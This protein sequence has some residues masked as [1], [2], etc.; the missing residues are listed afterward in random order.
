MKVFVNGKTKKILNAMVF[1]APYQKKDVANYAIITDD[2]ISTIKIVFDIAITNVVIRPQRYGIKYKII[3][4]Y[5]V[6]LYPEKR[7][8]FSVEPDSKIENS[9]Q[10]F[11]GMAPEIRH[12]EYENVIS[13]ESG[14]HF[15]DTIL[16]DKDNTLIY[17]KEGSIVH[18]RIKFSN[19]K[20]VAV[21]GF[22]ELTY[23]AYTNRTQLIDVNGCSDVKI[24][25]ITMKSSSNWNTR[26]LGCDRVH[27]DNIKIIGYRGNSDGVDVCSS[28]DVL[29][30]NIFTRVWDDSLVVK[31]L[32]CGDVYNVTFK[33]CV[34]WNDFA[35]PME[36]GVENRADKIY[37]IR[38][39]DIDLIHSVTGYPIMGI[40]HGDRAEIYDIYFENI[41]IEH[42]PGAQLLDLRVIPSAWNKDNIIGRIHNIYFKNINVISDPNAEILPYHSRIQG[43]SNEN[44]ISDIYFENISIF[45]KTARNAQE[46]GLQIF[47]YVDNIN[48]SATK[49]PFIERVKTKIKVMDY[50][51]CDDGNYDVSVKVILENTTDIEKSGSVMLKLSPEWKSKYDKGIEYSI[52]AHS[53]AEFVKRIKLPAGKYAFSLDSSNS[54]LECAVEFLNLKLLLTDKFEDCPSYYFCDSY[55]NS[56][57]EEVKFALKNDLLMIKTELLKKYNITL[58]AAKTFENAMVGDVLF[59]TEDTNSGKAPAIL[60]G[61]N[62]E[63]LE[64]PQIGCPEEIAFVFKNYPKVDIKNITLMRQ[65]NDIAIIPLSELDIKDGKNGFLLELVLQAKPEKRYEFTLFASPINKLTIRDPKVMAHMFIDAMGR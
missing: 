52:G 9:V 15:A 54:D 3:D 20:N 2:D 37:N 24:R 44:N 64:G 38:F 7:Y 5:T 18:G 11:C 28:R 13:F 26:I 61:K 12:E 49:G 48:F 30:E 57:D 29:V 65:L 58:Y 43:Y 23:E 50:L 34:L 39:L 6:E 4:E 19:C 47:D 63:Y 32:D 16:V 10:I 53:V 60:L 51:L 55:G 42:T 8:N 35:R 62:G 27:I 40:H 33:N 31:G 41:N 36:V 21:D 45:G 25:N 59:S 46:L 17:L 14:E 1:T 22:G 56:F